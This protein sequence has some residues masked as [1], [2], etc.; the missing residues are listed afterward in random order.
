MVE[1]SYFESYENYF[2]QWEDDAEVIAIPNG[3]TIAY[4][5]FVSE[6]ILTLAPQGLPPFGSLL[7]VIL[8][9]N[10]HAKTDIDKVF[11]LTSAALETVD[12]INLMKAITFLNLL[13]DLP[14]NYKKGKNR[15]LLFQI[16]FQNCHG[17]LAQ[18]KSKL[19][20]DWCLKGKFSN[21]INT[22]KA[23]FKFHSCELELKTIALL[24]TKYETIQDIMNQL[25]YL[26]EFD[27]EK[28]ELEVE[29]ENE[30][31]FLDKLLDNPKTFHVG[32]L[33]K[34]IW[35]GLN[36][37]AHSAMTSEQPIGGISDLSN[38][39]D[40]DRL[41][42]S[43]FAHDDL[44]FMSR[45]ANNEAL[46][47][48]R[49]IPPSN[50]TLERIFLID[51]S[52]KNWGIPKT[53]AFATVLALMETSKKEIAYSVYLVGSEYQV[54]SMNTVD[55]LITALHH[56][57][58]TLSPIEGIH[59][60][61]K[62]F[63]VSNKG[64]LFLITDSSTFRSENQQKSFFEVQNA[65]SYLLNVD[66][67]GNLDVFKCTKNGKKH[68]QHM[69]LPLKELW[70]KNSIFEKEN[71]EVNIFVTKLPILF[72]HPTNV[73]STCVCDSGEVFIITKDKCLFRSFDRNFDFS[74]KGWEL[75]TDNLPHYMGEFEI[76]LTK[77]GKYILLIFDK[78][79]KEI[80]LFDIYTEKAKTFDFKDWKYVQDKK[81][82]FFND[83]FYYQNYNGTWS[84]NL[85][86]EINEDQLDESIITNKKERY[87]NVLKQ[88]N[89]FAPLKNIKVIFINKHN[90][91]VFNQHVLH[92]NVGKHIMIE[93][94]SYHEEAI[95]GEFIHEN[96]V[97]FQDG[98]KIEV[99]KSGFLTFI[100]SN[101]ALPVFY[102]P[103][104]LH[105]S[106]GIATTK[107]C[108]GNDFFLKDKR[109]DL[110]LID[111]GSNKLEVIKRL[112]KLLSV[113]M[114]HA[115]SLI[116]DTAEFICKNVA[117]QHA[118]K[119]KKELT[120]LGATVEIQSNEESLESSPHKISTTIFFEKY[121]KTFIQQILAHGNS[122]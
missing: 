11:Q 106:L 119:I 121:M 39:G 120:E 13:S 60:F 87:L 90:Q 25:G 58:G 9:T 59:A 4:F 24:S 86:G 111:S 33:V 68:L 84:I 108:A 88:L 19:I 116:S 109:Y 27:L 45:L 41:L 35:S 61:L 117:L 31:P 12:H 114:N 21:E 74:K 95:V 36:I 14:E 3:N 66:S 98:S 49:E 104:Y 97:E 112:M 17:K 28:L 80:T 107:E 115:Q 34:R 26:P 70:N 50:N 30:K 78:Q 62:D 22:Q 85:E 72:K 48:Q 54:V 51:V 37:P 118:E 103:S 77:S 122:H 23:A 38:K 8:A 63:P 29:A 2:W 5:D 73:R 46:Y 79:K 75:I 56:V 110:V 32:T 57:E 81:F 40:F 76:G 99:H 16:L 101:S 52:L 1:N 89:S 94:S 83:K 105:A 92:L 64:E 96:L 53:I 82:Y 67:V 44:V 6:T 42:I 91:L 43:E 102:L 47:I 55:E 113:S 65:L 10:Q 18:K 69:Q 7:L 100:S 15:L 20:A 71:M 93:H